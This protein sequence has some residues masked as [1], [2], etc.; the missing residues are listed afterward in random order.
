MTSSETAPIRRVIDD[1]LCGSLSPEEAEL[2]LLALQGEA[3]DNIGETLRGLIA[4]IEEF[5]G[6]MGHT[7]AETAKLLRLARRRF[8]IQV[9]AS[10]PDETI[11]ED[12]LSSASTSMNRLHEDLIALANRVTELVETTIRDSQKRKELEIAGTVQKML[13]PADDLQVAGLQAHAWFRPADECSGDWWSLSKLGKTD[14]LLVVGD[15]TGH[16]APAAIVAATAKGALDM[17]RV[18][19]RDALKPFMAMNLLNHILLDSVKGEY[20]MT[21]L[22]VRYQTESRTVRIANAGHRSPW[23]LR[24]D[25]IHSVSGNR[26][27]PLGSSRSTKYQDEVVQLLPGDILV[28]FTDG[29]PEAESVDG[30]QFGER[31]M[32]ALCEKFYSE[33]PRGICDA[34][35]NAVEVHVGTLSRL[36]DDVTLVVVQVPQ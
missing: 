11:P 10:L 31:A 4:G 9:S 22:V 20:F 32:K 28:A 5:K 21:G 2:A 3:V 17:A 18:G 27:P 25:G 6:V 12:T 36:D 13:V 26:S 33:G 8:A 29:I 23:I 15:V 19:M 16:G 1:A 35:R 14:V 30:T 34:I 24:D 7:S